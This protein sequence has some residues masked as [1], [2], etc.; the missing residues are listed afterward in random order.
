[1]DVEEK[2]VAIAALISGPTRARMLW[3]L[4]DGRAYTATE[5]AV[6]ADV[7]STSASNHPSKLL[8]ADIL[9]VEAQGRHRYYS[10][11]RP[12]VAYAVEALANLAGRYGD[13]ETERQEAALKGGVKF[14]RTCYDHLAGYVGVKITDA[15]VAQDLMQINNSNYSITP[16]G[17]EWAAEIGIYQQDFR[18]KRRP[19]T[20]QCL[21]WSERK[22]HLAGQFGAKILSKMLEEKWFKRVQF[23]RELIITPKGQQQLHEQLGLDLFF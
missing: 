1:M 9:K 20:R 15:M 16:K 6:A 18:N 5:L 11:L 10:F 22:S 17:W 19:L 2:F 23:S 14:C 7:S 8:E 13:I 3:N 12:E 21:D 4:L